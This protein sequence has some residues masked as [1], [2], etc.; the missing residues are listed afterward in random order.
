M[1]ASRG[2]RPPDGPA[3]EGDEPWIPGPGSVLW[4]RGGDVRLL[5]VAGRSLLLQVAHPTVAAGVAQHS[6]YATDPW[7]RLRGTLDLYVAGV[8]FGWPDGSVAAAERLRRMHRRIEGVD[9][10]GRRY[11]ALDPEAFAWVHTTLAD[12]FLLM[13]ERYC[14]AGAAELDRAYEEMRLLGRLYE[15]PDEL[16]PADRRGHQAKVRSVIAEQLE[17]N[18][19][20]QNVLEQIS[21]PPPPGILRMAGPLWRLGTA[22]PGR[23][24]RLA[25][26][27]GIP[28][29]LRSR[30]GLSWTE[31]EQRELE[32]YANA[33]RRA[34]PLLPDRLRLLP[35]VHAAKRRAARSGETTRA[36]PLAA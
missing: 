27:G 5:L 31:A 17:D 21:K 19:V 20:A 26:A 7:G 2:E 9:F 10:H 36:Q 23:V 34:A 8:N 29:P 30:L 6:D 14:G 15:I 28:E 1:E 22:G 32:L 24:L 4:E 16:S 33:V 12:G 11:R 35:K 18:E 13:L 3:S 25:T